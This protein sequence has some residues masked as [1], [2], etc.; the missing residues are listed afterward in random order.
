MRG[1]QMKKCLG[2]PTPHDPALCVAV[3]ES[4]I[5]NLLLE[6]GYL[7]KKFSQPQGFVFNFESFLSHRSTQAKFSP[8]AGPGALERAP[9]PPADLARALR[10][11]AGAAL[12]L[13]GAPSTYQ[14]RA[15]SPLNPALLERQVEIFQTS[16]H[17]FHM[18]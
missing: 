11:L 15:P 6:N 16:D 7:C 17:S 2:L 4:F 5:A 12:R 3:T 18:F 13:K 1:P 10:A 9:G 14:P 8:P